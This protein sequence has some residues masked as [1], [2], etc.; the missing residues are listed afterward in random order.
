MGALKH[1][2]LPAF[3]LLHASVV[4]TCKD[5]S[6]WA[7]MV[8][9]DPED[10]NS[11]SLAM[12]HMLGVIRGFNLT[13]LFLCGWGCLKG[14][15]QFR[16]TLAVAECINFS[17]AAADAFRLGLNYLVPAS[18]ALIATIGRVV[19]GLEPGIFTTDKRD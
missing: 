10:E 19:S 2:I 12:K 8:A 3:G 5:F 1:V 13:L 9:Q 6:S 14:D 7:K 17:A 16:Q 11:K 18:M 15:A 4:F